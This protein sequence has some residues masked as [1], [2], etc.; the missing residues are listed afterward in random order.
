MRYSQ[1]NC[2]IQ[3]SYFIP[4][5]TWE[6]FEP[7]GFKVWNIWIQTIVAGKRGLNCP[8]TARL[9]RLGITSDRSN[10]GKWVFVAEKI[11][12]TTNILPKMWD[13]KLEWLVR[14]VIWVILQPLHYS[15]FRNL[16]FSETIRL[17]LWKPSPNFATILW[18]SSVKPSKKGGHIRPPGPIV[19]GWRNHCSTGEI[20]ASSQ[21]MFWLNTIGL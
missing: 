1:T 12:L 17:W 5:H 2:H 8:R 19:A 16:H 13:R 18:S 21:C 11:Q 4:S 7:R 15:S 3:V 14:L 20:Y 9:A 6:G 10:T